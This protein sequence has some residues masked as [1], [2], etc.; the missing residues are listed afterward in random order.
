MK[1]LVT[2]GAGF[3]GSHIVDNLIDQG[4]EVIVIDNLSSGSIANINPKAE[5]H[6]VDLKDSEEII[7][8][9]EIDLVIHCAAQ[10]DVRVSLADPLKDMKENIENSLI[11]LENMRKFDVNKIIFLST[12]GALYNME[13]YSQPYAETDPVNP[14]SPYGIAK[15]T[16][17]NYLNFYKN[18]HNFST[19]ILRLANVYG[20]RNEKGVIY[21]FKQAIKEGKPITIFG[22]SQTRDFIHVSDVVSA[23]DYATDQVL[24][25]RMYVD[26]FNV[27]TGVKT[28]LDT[29]ASLLNGTDIIRGNRL[30]GEII[31]TSLNSS[32]LRHLGWEP[33]MEL[34]E[35]LA[36]S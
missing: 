5:F 31:D 2:G 12:G 10:T 3:L 33:R 13:A 16:I 29:L 34:K 4:H 35:G 20:A 19:C 1:T 14:Q 17:E 11:L 30:P 28:S 9:N 23:I 27:G 21:N 25:G 7:A 24:K 18:Y 32:R 6:K 8:N 22:G 26:V 15:Y 36:I